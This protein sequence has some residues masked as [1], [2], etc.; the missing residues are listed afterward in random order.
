MLLLCTYACYFSL[1]CSVTAPPR[2]HGWQRFNHL[3][4]YIPP[5]ILKGMG[6]MHFED[7]VL[8]PSR[9]NQCKFPKDI[10]VLRKCYIIRN[11]EL[12]SLFIDICQ[13]IYI[14]NIVSFYCS[15]IVW[16]STKL[17][18]QNAAYLLPLLHPVDG[19]RRHK[20]QSLYACRIYICAAITEMP[21]ARHQSMGISLKAYYSVNYNIG[22]E[23]SVFT[24]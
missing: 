7:T 11:S 3:Y 5:A 22:G 1:L 10:S 8:D 9:C 18:F 4:W 13:H 12:Q 14:Y 21:G 19:I 23:I 20:K 15:R 2:V 6:S 17:L 16:S 24:H